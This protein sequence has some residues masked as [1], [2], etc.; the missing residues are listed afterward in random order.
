[1][2]QRDI[3]IEKN[4][5]DKRAKNK[6]SESTYKYNKGSDAI[7][8]SIRSPYLYF[9]RLIKNLKKNMRVLEIG[10]GTGEYTGSILENGSNVTASDISPNC[11]KLIENKYQ[12]YLNNGTLNTV[13]ANMENL[14]FD[15]ETFDAVV[16]AGSLSYGKASIVDKE[17]N[18]VLRKGGIFL[19][20]DSLNDN[21]IYRFNRY[22]HFL[23]HNRSRLTLENIP[24]VYRLENLHHYYSKISLTYF[25]GISWI[26]F[27][28]KKIIGRKI[29][30]RL[31]DYYDHVFSVKSSAFK[32][33]IIARK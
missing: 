20:V 28:L 2:Y 13:V 15:D 17:I 19:C 21:F 12:D 7:C 33:V 1:M 26:M 23:K 6:L 10:S 30:K 22:I 18:R 14:P 24:D 27:F 8:E 31:S 11:I 32:F 25:G 3:E 9:E 5:F 29:A 16:I 4:R